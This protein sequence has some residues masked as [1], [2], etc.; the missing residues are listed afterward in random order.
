MNRKAAKNLKTA[1]KKKSGTAGGRFYRAEWLVLL[2]ILVKTENYFCSCISLDQ[3]NVIPMDISAESVNSDEL[4]G[5]ATEEH[6]IGEG[7]AAQ[8]DSIEPNELVAS[9][10]VNNG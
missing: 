2:N 9:V 8:N 6:G 4:N 7:S 10:D 1:I 5:Q 3:A